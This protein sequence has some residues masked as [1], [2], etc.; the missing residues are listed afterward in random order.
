M[1]FQK[2]DNKLMWERYMNPEVRGLRNFN[3]QSFDTDDDYLTPN[4]DQYY[5]DEEEEKAVVLEFEPEGSLVP[6]MDDS[7]GFGDMVEVGGDE[8]EE[9]IDEVLYSDIKKLADYSNRLLKDVNHGELE[10]WMIAKLI[11]ASEYVSDVWHRL[12]AKTDFANKGVQDD[13]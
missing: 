10:T 6:D 13:I 1:R 3:D 9:E 2:D 8:L 12:D 4:I 5:S 11:K 7:D